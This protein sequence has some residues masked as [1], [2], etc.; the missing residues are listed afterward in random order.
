[1]VPPQDDPFALVQREVERL[2]RDLVY[3]RHPGAHFA[4]QP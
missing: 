1:M 3:H 4:E 2:W